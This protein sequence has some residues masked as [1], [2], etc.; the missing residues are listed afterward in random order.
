MVW[1]D[2]ILSEML[3][4][5]QGGL[6]NLVLILFTRQ[7]GVPGREGVFPISH[8]CT[9]GGLQWTRI[10]RSFATPLCISLI[11]IIL[12]LLMRIAEAQRSS[13]VCLRSHS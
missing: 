9:T 8:K 11:T 13:T 2:N 5:D 10:Y 4:G 3:S 7:S 6:K 12:I 1:V